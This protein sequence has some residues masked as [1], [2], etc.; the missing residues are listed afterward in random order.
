MVMKETKK[1]LK[2]FMET[3]KTQKTM[4]NKNIFLEFLET[5]WFSGLEHIVTYAPY[6]LYYVSEKVVSYCENKCFGQSEQNFSNFFI[7]ITTDD[8]RQQGFVIGTNN[9][10]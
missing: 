9:N 2:L 1:L 6:R 10:K 4:K 7:Q 8:H 5:Y 3:K